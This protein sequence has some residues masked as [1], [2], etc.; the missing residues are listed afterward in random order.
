MHANRAARDL[1]TQLMNRVTQLNAAAAVM[2]L[3]GFS[4]ALGA[5]WESLDPVMTFGCLTK[6]RRAEAGRA[7][8]GGG[9]GKATGRQDFRKED[10]FCVRACV[11]ARM[12]VPACARLWSVSR[13]ECRFCAAR[14]IVSQKAGQTEKKCFQ[15]SP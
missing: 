2:H 11:D 5:R 3:V 14:A 9:R 13:A 12:C 15:K 1:S 10:G 4:G 8:K 7:G 6:L